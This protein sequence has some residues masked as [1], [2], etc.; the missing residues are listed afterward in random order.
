MMKTLIL[1]IELG[2]TLAMFLFV[3]NMTA[4]TMDS[5]HESRNVM[6]QTVDDF[7]QEISSDYDGQEMPTGYTTLLSDLKGML[8]N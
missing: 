6:S 3:I 5:Y 4:Y 1:L 8:K 2:L 7:E